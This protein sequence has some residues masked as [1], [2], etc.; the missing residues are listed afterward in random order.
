MF[1]WT[2]ELFFVE[3]NFCKCFIVII[4][5]RY[6]QKNRENWSKF[7]INKSLNTIIKTFKKKIE[8][9]WKSDNEF[10]IKLKRKFIRMCFLFN[11]NSYMD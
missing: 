6:S 11:E 8:N 3:D 7:K 4:I 2:V 10:P 9:G 5:S 1:V